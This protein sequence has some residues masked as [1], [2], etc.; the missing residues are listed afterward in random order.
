MRLLPLLVLPYL[1]CFVS[2]AAGAQ[3][4]EPRF[5]Y[6]AYIG[7]DDVYV[8][9]GP[10]Q[11]YYP[12]DKLKAGQAVEVYRHDPGGWYA[13]RPPKDS[14]TWISGR[15]LQWDLNTPKVPGVGTIK[16]DAVAARVGSRFSDIRDVIQVRL[17]DLEPVEVREKV[18]TG[19]GSSVWYKIAPP[20]GEFR[21]VFGKYVDRADSHNGVR[22]PHSTDNAVSRTESTAAAAPASPALESVAQTDDQPRDDQQ[23]RQSRPT[24]DSPAT[25]MPPHASDIV[26]QP[27]A[28]EEPVYGSSAL[29]AMSPDEFQVELEQLDTA[30][31]IMVVEEPTVWEFA[32][33]QQRADS[34]VT[35]AE[36]ALERGRARMLAAKIARFDDIKTRYDEVN[37]LRGEVET[38]NRQLAQLIPKDQADRLRP[39]PESRFDGVGQLTRV[40]SPNLG[41]PRYALVD[42]S[43]GV[44]CYVSPAPGVNLRH[45]EGSRV[46][47]S[48]TRGYIPEQHA[49]HVMARHVS[50][51]DTGRL[52]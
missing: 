13:I 8:R 2:D 3:E 28:A 10:G 11:N 6:K 35:Q 4:Q 41:A 31:S 50:V 16:G 27:A 47:I 26:R 48:G 17:H 1:V 40:K 14:F 29:R 33:L 49:H 24:G 30:L 9:S 22:K 21:W 44:Q 46:G 37:R 7:G 34:L 39:D 5:P 51:L 45:Y 42:K 52:R 15:H 23:P 19:N 36:T 32:T 38:S 43:G 12:T 25:A 20:S 18:A